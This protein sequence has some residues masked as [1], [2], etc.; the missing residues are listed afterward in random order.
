MRLT[1]LALLLLAGCTGSGTPDDGVGL[2]GTGW[3]DPFP[4]SHMVGDDGKLALTADHLPTLGERELPGHL[5][6]WRS[7]F[8]VAQTA[9]VRLPGVD[10][11]DLPHWRSPTPGEGGVRLVDLD[12]GTFLPVMAELDAW[13]DQPGEPALIVRP[14]RAMTPDHRVAIVVM[15]SVAPR[16]DRFHGLISGDP[17][18][19]LAEHEDHY[20]ELMN[21][22]SELGVPTDQVAL[23]WDF[24]IG[25]GARPARTAIAARKASDLSWTFDDVAE[26]D[27]AART[28][29]RTA[30]GSLTVTGFLDDN[31]VLSLDDTGAAQRT[32]T[33]EVDIWVHVP[34]SVKDKPAGSVPVMIFG[35]GIFGSPEYYLGANNPTSTMRLASDAGYIVVASSWRGLSRKDTG[36]AIGVAAS[37][38]RLPEL[39]SHLV[40]SQVGTRTIADALV[41]GDLLDDPVFQGA[42]GQA[43]GDSE[44]LIYYGISLG[45]IQGGVFMGLDAPVDAAVLHVPGAMWATMLERSSNFPIFEEQVVDEQPD[46]YARQVL[47]SWSQLH[48]D[49]ADPI[50]YAERIGE[51]TVLLQEA[52]HDE[53]VPNLTTRALARSAGLPAVGPSTQAPWGLEQLP[54][55]QGPSAA[56]WVQFDP[57]LPAPQDANRP[58]KVTE[59]H[60]IPRSWWEQREQVMR[61]LEKGSAGTIMHPCGADAACSPSNRGERQ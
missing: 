60:N 42:Q 24:P 13:P 12:S 43:L 5:S 57:E 29:F 7:G 39:P 19:S 36:L 32:G 45:G 47:Y 11:S 4:S 25:D 2:L 61:F 18:A 37:F 48:W 59:A 15:D 52:L 8:S 10:P 51:R 14:L 46:P 17:P 23:A 34:D 16:P 44:R 49:P 58:A 9:V 22:L 6:S 41:H 55:P 3:S 1:P 30:Q 40:Q 56:G 33:F 28:A 50:N 20:V 54:A 35:H 26:G 31:G 27:D 21:D 53:Q 38:D